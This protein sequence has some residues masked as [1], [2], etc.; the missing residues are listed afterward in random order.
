[1]PGTKKNQQSSPLTHLIDDLRTN[2]VIRARFSEEPVALME[3]YGVHLSPE[4]AREVQLNIIEIYAKLD[5]VLKI[6]E[7][8]P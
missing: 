1:M 4:A 5:K 6:M 3:D 7:S 2:A 8:I